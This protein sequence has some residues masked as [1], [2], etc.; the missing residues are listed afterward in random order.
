LSGI[1]C[2]LTARVVIDVLLLIEKGF[3]HFSPKLVSEL[4]ELY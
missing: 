4:Q 2:E 3:S 1:D